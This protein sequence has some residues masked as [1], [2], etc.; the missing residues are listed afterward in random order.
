MRKWE[1]QPWLLP[2]Q[3][4][5]DITS[6]FGQPPG[7]RKWRRQ[8]LVTCDL[9]ERNDYRTMLGVEKIKGM[10]SPGFASVRVRNDFQG[11]CISLRRKLTFL[12]RPAPETGSTLGGWGFIRKWQIWGHPRDQDRDLE[13]SWLTDSQKI[14]KE[15]Y[16]VLR[17]LYSCSGFSVICNYPSLF[18]LLVMV[19]H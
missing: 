10:L 2:E 3:T 17:F 15:V 11:P 14:W 1:D 13:L 8:R 16:G 6:E 18:V 9:R 7:Y 12:P 19:S 5:V 4:E